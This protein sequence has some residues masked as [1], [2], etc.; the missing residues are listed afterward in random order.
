[1]PRVEVGEVPNSRMLLLALVLTLALPVLAKPYLRVDLRNGQKVPPRFQVCGKTSRD[2][3]VFIEVSSWDGF[4]A[5]FEVRTDARGNFALP[6][7][8]EGRTITTHVDIKVRSF[9]V[10]RK[11]SKELSR[12]VILDR[13]FQE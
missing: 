4:G 11:T 6:V 13:K 5:E 3:V 1:M 8:I 9:D 12:Y 7:F 2:C 10:R